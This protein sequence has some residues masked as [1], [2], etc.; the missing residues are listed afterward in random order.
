MV[1]VGRVFGRSSV[2]RLVAGALV[3]AGLAVTPVASAETLGGGGGELSPDGVARVVGAA[4]ADAQVAP[5]ADAVPVVDTRGGVTVPDS[6]SGISFG[7]PGAD[8]LAETESATVVSGAGASQAAVP[9]VGEDGIRVSFV[10]NSPSDPTVYKV[11]VG[12]AGQLVQ[13]AGGSVLVIG[14]SGDVEAVIAAPWAKDATG[15]DVPTRYVIEG[16]TLTQVVDHRAGDFQYPIVADPWK[17]HWWGI[18][19]VMSNKATNRIVKTLAGGAGAA[20]VA[21]ALAAAGV[22]SSPGVIPSGLAV[23]LLTFGATSLDLCNF[24]DRGI[25]F[26]FTYTGQVWCWPR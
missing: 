3:A 26:N 10:I 24:N 13:A 5:G 4:A 18:Q 25:T 9:T 6:D 7:L 20:G 8:V 19:L 14:E 16:N 12:G 1:F 21:A 22:I 11:R 15:V 2:V 17:R 23:A